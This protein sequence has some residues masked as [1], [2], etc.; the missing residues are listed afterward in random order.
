MVPV[1]TMLLRVYFWPEGKAERWTVAASTAQL[2]A[3]S[4]S[5]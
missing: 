3:E 4:G 5:Q 1:E 2:Q